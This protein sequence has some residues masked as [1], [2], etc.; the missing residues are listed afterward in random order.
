MLL[1]KSSWIFWISV[2]PISMLSGLR[3]QSPTTSSVRIGT[4]PAGLQYYVDGQMY[5]G[6]V[7]LFWPKGSKHSVST[8]LLQNGIQPKTQYA[9]NGWNTNLG[10]PADPTD[11]TADPGLTDIQATFVTQFAV[12]LSYYF[13]PAGTDISTCPSPG[14]VLMNDQTFIQNGEIYVNAG[15]TVNVQALPNPGF[16][17]GGWGPVPGAGGDSQAF[18]NSYIVNQPIIIRP[19]FGF[20]VPV[21]VSIV[22]TPP[23]LQILVDQTPM[24]S[25]VSLEWGTG[26]THTVAGISPQNDLQSRLWLFD[27]WSDAG[28]FSHTYTVPLSATS[29]TLSAKYVSG[30]LV[31]FLT[32]PA[33]LKLTVDGRSNWPDYTF[34]WVAGSKHTVIAPAQQADL[35]GRQYSFQ[36]WS[37]GG[38]ATQTITASTD[39]TKNRYTAR[40]GLQ[41]SIN[42]Q[43]TPAS[44][45]IQ[46]DGQPCPTPCSVSRPVGTTVQIS[47][48]ASSSAGDG[49]RL[50]FQGWADGG[51]A[52]RTVTAN[53]NPFTLNASYRLRYQLKAVADPPEGVTWSIQPAS[54][55]RYFD[56]LSQV[57]VV[58]SAN[59]GFTFMNWAG[60]VAGATPSVT[61]IMD[62]PHSVRA[63]MDPVPYIAPSGIQNS[64]AQTP[65]NTVAPGSAVAVYGLNLSTDVKVGPSGPLVQTLDDVTVRAG[66]RLLPLF[67]VSPG[68]LNVQMPSDL[69]EGSQTLVVHR[70][71]KPEASAYFSVKRNAPGLF[72]YLKGDQT[73]VVARHADGSLI[74]ADSPARRN[75]TITLYGTGLGPYQPAPPDGF[76][77][78]AKPKYTLADPVKIVIGDQ[79]FD[80][81]WAGAAAG[82]VGLTAVQ[83]QI[84]DQVPHAT[85][86]DLKVRVQGHESNSVPLAI[87]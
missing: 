32:D 61:V 37:N 13:C 14:R 45:P 67:F 20:A 1:K 23:G 78:P 6:P 29:V 48:P 39:I 75:E 16:V 31:T 19:Q 83:F 81:V 53:G 28:A 77:V 66:G 55:D 84:S 70:E 12:D 34:A 5:K 42:I 22:T 30:N 11:I 80:P 82:R 85:T 17:F 3:G 62:G 41:G 51:S 69:P 54:T 63:E 40:Y 8:D 44:V 15:G 64:A 58:V 7:T 57:K 46:V 68:Q 71:G 18:I 49:A 47:A 35:N 26:S 79:A 65:D 25:P 73:F 60:D 76:P 24:T 72:T 87:E 86:V 10:I 74:S 4:D 50:D 38:S 33:G 2:L 56:A 43:S 27:S 21:S 52:T 59:P 9:F 36:S